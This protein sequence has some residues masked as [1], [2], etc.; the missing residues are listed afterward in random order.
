MTTIA[1]GLTI[2]IEGR[3]VVY[4]AVSCLIER[5]AEAGVLDSFIIRG[6]TENERSVRLAERLGFRFQNVMPNAEKIGDRF[7]DNRRYRLRVDAEPKPEK[8][9][10]PLA[11]LASTLAIR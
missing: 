11:S 1:S 8:R 4:A 9:Y 10:F 5:Y 2:T 6:S 7:L 3:S